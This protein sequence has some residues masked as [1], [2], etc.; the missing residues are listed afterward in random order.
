MNFTARDLAA[1]IVI[2]AFHSYRDCCFETLLVIKKLAS[3][4]ALFILL[5]GPTKF[6]IHKDAAG[7]DLFL[8]KV[9]SLPHALC[10]TTKT[11]ISIEIQRFKN[12]ESLRIKDK[13]FRTNSDIQ[14]L[15]SKISSLSREIV[16]KLSR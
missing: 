13:D 12:H 5:N 15:P 8:A 4:G 9:G 2:I 6:L 3:I 10:S 11:Y 14:D 1:K 16:S 7:D